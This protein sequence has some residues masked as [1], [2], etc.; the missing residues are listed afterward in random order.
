M[1][2]TPNIIHTA[3]H[4]V[5]AQVVTSRTDILFSFDIRAPVFWKGNVNMLQ[6]IARVDPQALSAV[7]LV[8][9]CAK[10]TAPTIWTF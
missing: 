1:P 10:P 3:K 4:T 2:V 6:Q 5:K 7:G 9:M 8:L